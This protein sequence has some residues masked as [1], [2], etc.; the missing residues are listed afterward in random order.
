MLNISD[1]PGS[2]CKQTASRK[3]QGTRIARRRPDHRASW[4]R[5][6]GWGCL[7]VVG[8][9]NRG[10]IPFLSTSWFQCG[11]ELCPYSFEETIRFDPLFSGIS[12]FLF[13]L[14]KA[15]HHNYFRFRS[16]SCLGWRFV[17]IVGIF[18]F[19]AIDVC[20]SVYQRRQSHTKHRKSRELP[21]SFR[22]MA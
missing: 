22:C 20:M 14:S 16:T 7:G 21:A 15:K 9:G 6:S 17:S 19:A 5:E 8:Q 18:S 2:L 10:T 11:M 3:L 12:R 13:F 1:I 4:L